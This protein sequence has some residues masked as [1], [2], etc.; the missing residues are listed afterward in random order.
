[1]KPGKG[2]QHALLAL[3]LLLTLLMGS[4]QSISAQSGRAVYSQ[5]SSLNGWL[6]IVWG[7]SS[8]GTATSER[9]LLMDESGTVTELLLDKLPIQA[10]GGILSL[11]RKFVSVRGVSAALRSRQGG[12]EALVVSS[13]SLSPSPASGFSNG[14]VLPLL[15]G[16]KPFV[17]ILCK[18]SDQANEPN[19]LAFFQ[20]MY[21]SDYPGLDH[22]WREQSYDTVNIVGSTAAGWFVLPHPEIY[23]NPTDTGQGTNLG[24]LA[25]DCIAAA[26]PSVNFTSFSGINM[27][28]NTDFDNGW[29]WG[30]SGYYTL[31]GVTRYWSITWE[32]PWS[33]SSITVIAHEMGHGFGL[34]HSSGNYGITYDNQWDVMSDA[35][36]N[37]GR[38]TDPTYGC[39]GQHTISYHKDKLGW[40][41]VNQK[42]IAGPET[43]IDLTLEQLALPTVGNYK[44]VQIPISGSSTHFYTVEVRR[45][46]GYDYKLP[47]QAVII[48]EVDTTRREPAHVVDSD[49]NTNTGDAGARWT[50]GETF[51]D[52]ANQL[53]VSVLSATPT[54][55]Q[56]NIQCNCPNP[57]PP[58]TPANF[59]IGASTP[60][61]V[62]VEWDDVSFETGYIIYSWDGSDFVYVATLEAGITAFTETRP[63]CDWEASYE[64]SAF[65]DF[66]ESPHAASVLASTQICPDVDT[67]FLNG[68]E[69][70]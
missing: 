29:A 35:W 46:T 26:D 54:G 27:M 11:N 4:A 64:V 30:G 31:D 41:P 1:M 48:H 17:S 57:V 28:F 20:G 34:P 6:T 14:E 15:S 23:Y 58:A 13:I 36:S 63:Y 67:I 25:E 69:N 45:Q 39:L 55:F 24:L 62:T 38:L 49:G 37:C 21:S 9:F 65:N 60:T 12:P 19:D 5:P 2:L 61:S 70:P 43:N 42:Y 66:G 40:I 16:S 3:I 32:P 51:N 56:V 68:F 22:Y 8:T 44:M 18:F 10:Q 53:S 33:Y 7:D 52:G 59:R 47:G 50:V